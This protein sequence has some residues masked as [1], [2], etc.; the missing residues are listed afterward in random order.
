MQVSVQDECRPLLKAI[1][2]LS[3]R[4]LQN[5]KKG[6]FATKNLVFI[7]C[8]SFL[9]LREQT[10]NILKICVCRMLVTEQKAEKGNANKEF[11]CLPNFSEVCCLGHKENSDHPF[12]HQK[13]MFSNLQHLFYAFFLAELIFNTIYSV[14]GRLVSI[15]ATKICNCNNYI[16]S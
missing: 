14:V 12:K 9:I 7:K 16:N 3:H 15:S 2:Y 13:K 4:S 6:L 5:S 1:G 10:L 8:L 11:L